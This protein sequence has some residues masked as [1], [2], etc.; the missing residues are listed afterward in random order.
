VGVLSFTLADLDD[1]GVSEIIML[2]SRPG[3][4]WNHLIVG[5]LTGLP[6]T[7]RGVTVRLTRPTAGT[8]IT[9]QCDNREHV[10]ELYGSGGYQDGPRREGHVGCGQADTFDSMQIS[11]DGTTVDVPAGQTGTVTLY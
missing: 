2:P 1:D 8:R 5:H 11:I 7:G 6:E 4:R 3:S 9:V 10:V